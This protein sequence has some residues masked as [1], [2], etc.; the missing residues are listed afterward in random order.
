MRIEARMRVEGEIK[1]EDEMG[2]RTRKRGRLGNEYKGRKKNVA[3]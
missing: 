2:G 1:D 3:T